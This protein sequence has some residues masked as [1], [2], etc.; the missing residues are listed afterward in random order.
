V[1]RSQYVVPMTCVIIVLVNCFF[2]ALLF[3]GSHI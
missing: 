3:I 2:R 1:E